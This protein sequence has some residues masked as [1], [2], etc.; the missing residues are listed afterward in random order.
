MDK[1]EQ[2]QGDGGAGGGQKEEEKEEE[3]EE[4]EEGGSLKDKSTLGEIKSAVIAN[5]EA[6][7]KEKRQ[8]VGKKEKTETH[9]F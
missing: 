6:Q 2:R 8:R 9:L 1:V 3:E 4:E 5:V 7:K